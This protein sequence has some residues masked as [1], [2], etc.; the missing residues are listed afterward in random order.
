MDSYFQY[1]HNLKGGYRFE[2]FKP[3]TQHAITSHFIRQL[4]DLN[5][6]ELG[7][8][9]EADREVLSYVAEHLDLKIYHKSIILTT[10]TSSYV[11]DVDFNNV[12]AIINLRKVN[13]IQHPNKLFRAVNRLLPDSGIYIGRLETYTER[14]IV[15]YR[16]MGR[17]LGQF[18]WL[19]DFLLHRVI[20]RIP[21]L[22]E[23]YYYLT[24][25][26]FHAI[27]QSEVLGRLVYCGFE[28]ADFRR[29]NGLSYFVA[30]KIKEPSEQN[31]AT[32]YP[33]IKLLRVGKHGKMIGVYKLRTMH[34]Y[35]EFLQDYVIRLNGYNDKGK[36]ADDFRVTRWGKSFRKLWIDEL[37]QLINVL[38]GEMKLVGL[39][40]LSEVRYNQFP[41]DLQRKRIRY[42]PGCIPPY[43]ALKMPDDK[44]N[45]EAERIYI[46]DLARHPYTTDIRYFIKAVYNILANKI[47]SS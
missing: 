22:D 28:I 38:K 25:G 18:L 7:I 47:R 42:K 24:N 13:N 46:R 17:Y 12:R 40:P 10:S 29:I 33:I 11:D 39:R 6:L 15:I 20:P 31:H 5:A 43:V 30:I 41:P 32:H 21:Y 44:A 36:P 27:S 34:P 45:I 19:V 4:D 16:Q 35:S 8:S 9:G 23:L 2:R 37:P 3:A 1:V 14:K 26:E